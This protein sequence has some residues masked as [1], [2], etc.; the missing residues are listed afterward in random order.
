MHF[1]GCVEGLAVIAL[2]SSCTTTST[3]RGLPPGA[4]VELDGQLR[5]VDALGA[6]TF[7]MGPSLSEAQLQV[8]QGDRSGEM[9]IARDRC[10]FSECALGSVASLTGP[11][12]GFI[13][14]QL[15]HESG[16][17]SSPLAAG[18]G[19]QTIVGT[20][21]SPTVSALFL[22]STCCA[23]GCS[24]ALLLFA[25]HLPEE[26]SAN[27]LYLYDEGRSGLLY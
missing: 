15:G 22:G 13:G 7:E 18:G 4:T 5:E 25:R 14:F 21:V 26:T 9:T 23:L 27:N 16:L 11:L 8:W 10:A 17:F 2:L 24:P 1:R 19:L 6:A 20:A 12:L 3:V